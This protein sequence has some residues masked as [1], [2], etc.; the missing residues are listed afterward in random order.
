MGFRTLIGVAAAVLGI[1]GAAIAADEAPPKPDDMVNTPPF[2]HWGAFDVG[3]RV[4]QKQVVSLPDGRK[5][6]EVIVH[7]LLKNDPKHVVV[8]T[9][10][11]DNSKDVGETTRTVTTYSPTIRMS[12]VSM[13]S[14]DTTLTEGK[15]DMTVK[16]KKIE[17]EWTA[18]ETRN[19][20]DVWKEKTWTARD[21]PGGIIRETLVHEQGG[22]VVSDS[23]L[24][25]VDFKLGS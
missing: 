20:D 17:T 23:V 6:E 22:K 12:E 1:A 4:T 21:I 2:H 25:L 24:E 16:G 15:E 9:V 18:T 11:T 7:R 13:T 8:E 19:G 10:V 3:T 14:P 5:V